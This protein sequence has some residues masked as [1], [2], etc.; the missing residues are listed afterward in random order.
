MAHDHNKGDDSSPLPID[1]N[2]D[3]DDDNDVDAILN[4]MNIDDD[5]NILFSSLTNNSSTGK[6]QGDVENDVPTKISSRTEFQQPSLPLQPKP[7][8]RHITKEV[9]NDEEEQVDFDDYTNNDND[10]NDIDNNIE[11]MIQTS[12]TTKK[13]RN[14]LRQLLSF[15]K[16]GHTNNNQNDDTAMT[17]NTVVVIDPNQEENSTT[18]TAVPNN[19]PIETEDGEMITPLP[20][21]TTII[22]PPIESHTFSKHYV[23]SS[24]DQEQIYQLQQDIFGTTKKGLKQKQSPTFLSSLLFPTTSNHSSFSSLTSTWNEQVDL[25]NR[26]MMM[27]T[28]STPATTIGS[29]TLSS[30]SERSMTSISE[31]NM[32]L[33]DTPFRTNHSKSIILWRSDRTIQMYIDTGSDSTTAATTP[34]TN[35]ECETPCELIVWTT[36]IMILLVPSKT[37]SRHNNHPSNADLNHPSRD[38]ATIPHHHPQ[39]YQIHTV[40]PWTDSE[41]I[42]FY[43]SRKNRMIPMEV[44]HTTATTT[45]T[46]SQP[47]TA[48]TSSEL[49]NDT[50]VAYHNGTVQHSY[51]IR[52]LYNLSHDDPV[53]SPSSAAVVPDSKSSKKKQKSTGNI[54]VT[55][56]PTKA[57]VNIAFG[58]QQE[59]DIVYHFITI[60]MIQ[61]HTYHPSTGLSN[62]QGD[63]M[64]HTNGEEEP[65]PVLG[66]QYHLYYEPFFTMAV[67]NMLDENR[68]KGDVNEPTPP[69]DINQLDTY[70]G[71]TPLHYAVYYNHVPAIVNL[72]ERNVG[73][74][75]TIDLNILDEN[76][77][78]TP[79]D[80]CIMYELPTST[81]DLLKQYGATKLTVAT[82]VD[83]K[84]SATSHYEMK[85]ELFGKVTATEQILD[86]RRY[87][88]RREMELQQQMVQEQK[89]QN[90][91]LLLQ[92]QQRGEQIDT[93]SSGATNLNQNA[94]EY[95][96]MAQQIKERTKRQHDKYNTWFPFG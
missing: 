11:V 29:N 61:Y 74:T 75:N 80:Y 70:N 18:A 82:A 63:R 40:I 78:W 96:S 50:L 25:W 77:S 44:N 42:Q 85:G 95:A 15:R 9:D 81:M 13:H 94:H 38:D 4:D 39:Q 1:N 62:S 67:T 43:S 76:H 27:K 45:I 73:S 90:H 10:S 35:D 19:I 8:S 12:P 92:M 3:D 57:M 23:V 72:I 33:A 17:N 58:S 2:K 31:R 66:W 93:L 41:Y 56:R 36:G 32:P 54:V 69:H 22:I 5:Y 53:S 86:E 26:I 83:S 60:A 7:A 30:S 87:N 51:G 91:N 16:P 64:R 47:A 71:M 48:T 46:T 65:Q 20:K 59:R 14:R 84:K 79:L 37:S 68:Q 6:G 34:V 28:D 55:R 88:R 89:N 21:L 24:N 52:F 49:E